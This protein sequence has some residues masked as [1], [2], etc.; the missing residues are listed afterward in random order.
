MHGVTGW[1][2]LD[3]LDDRTNV[4][5]SMQDC[6]ELQCEVGWNLVFSGLF[7][8]TWGCHQE[9]H[10]ATKHERGADETGLAWNT[11]L[12]SWIIRE[13]RQVWLQ[14]NDEVHT[15]NDGNSKMERETLDQV[16][17]LYS[18]SS[19][20]SYLDRQI[21]A[22]PIEEK[23]KKPIQTLKQWLRNT[24]PVVNKC[25]RDYAQ[26]M[27]SGQRDIRQYLQRQQPIG[28][29]VDNPAQSESIIPE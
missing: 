2:H 5:V 23:M 22:E 29:P 14:R 28:Q 7:D 21:F 17:K 15:A 16:Q 25:M 24:V 26:K 4:P 19:D 20:I 13:A 10:F 18:M 3:R 6:Y 12:C 9:T 1:L 8:E 11:K 27:R